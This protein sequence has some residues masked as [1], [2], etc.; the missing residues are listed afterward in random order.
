MPMDA[1]GGRYR[2]EEKDG[3][4][5]VIDIA[6]GARAS[7]VTPSP[8]PGGAPPGGAGGVSSPP[9]LVD[10]YGRLLLS[11]VVRRWDAA[12]GPAEQK[13]LG[14][15]LV[16][17]SVFPIFVLF[18]IFAGTS[19]IWLL[20]PIVLP[21]AFWGVGAVMRLKRDTGKIGEL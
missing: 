7:P 9:G 3:R 5:T 10:R 12:L 15:A 6:T 20:L 11:L 17:V 8:K 16:A 4:L 1:P 13:R 21:A 18:A 2:V 14:R 19:L